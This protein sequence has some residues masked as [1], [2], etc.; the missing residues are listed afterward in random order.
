MT[1]FDDFEPMRIPTASGHIFLRRAGQGP[2][3]LL[4]HGFPETHLMWR[5]V[6]P[7]L[8]DGFTILCADLRGYGD[9]GCPPSDAEHMPQ[10]G[11]QD[12]GT[13]HRLPRARLVEPERSARKLVRGR[14]RCTWYLA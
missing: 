11:R 4:L 12:E 8:A 3:L 1:P 9:S 6:A 5:E 2:P 13:P 7:H 14:R 10:P